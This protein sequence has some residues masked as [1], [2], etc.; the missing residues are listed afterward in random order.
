MTAPVKS[1]LRQKMLTVMRVRDLSSKTEESYLH[2]VEQLAAYYHR[3]PAELSREEVVG[4]LEDCVTNRKLARSTVN[5]PHCG[6]ATLL[7]IGAEKAR[8][9]P[10]PP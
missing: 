10:E 6:Q 3:S 9:S 4:F 5:C 2:A 7:L 1:P 8:A